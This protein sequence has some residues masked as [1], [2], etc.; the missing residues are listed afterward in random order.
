M[1]MPEA[2]LQFQILGYRPHAGWPEA[3]IVGSLLRIPLPHGVEPAFDN[4]PAKIDRAR[5]LVDE[6][7]LAG[8]VNHQIRRT[9]MVEPLADFV[10]Q[11]DGVAYAGGTY[12]AMRM[13]SSH[14]AGEVLGKQFLAFRNFRT[15]RR[16]GRH[17]PVRRPRRRLDTGVRILLIVITDNQAVVIAIKRAGN[18]SETDVGRAAVA[19]LADDI[20]ERTLPLSF[21]NHGFIGRGHTC[22]KAARTANLRVRPRYI[23]GGAQ[24]RTVRDIH[25]AGRAD[26]DRV[27][28][29]GFARHSV[30]DRRPAASTC[31]VAGNERL[32]PGQL[33][34]VET[35]T[36]IRVIKNRQQLPLNFYRCHVNSSGTKVFVSTTLRIRPNGCASQSSHASELPS[37][38]RSSS[39]TPSARSPPRP[40]PP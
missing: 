3:V 9:L 40:C 6:A 18:R 25:A 12:V 32:A 31:T 5:R 24:I 1:K 33:R 35:R 8:G 26:Q 23:V 37:F 29:R 38:S 20:R 21:S 34:I 16:E 17:A 28:A 2:S 39:K 36:L 11:V 7:F 13:A 4:Q 10:H 27:V 30:L 22:R 15:G 19:G 14:H